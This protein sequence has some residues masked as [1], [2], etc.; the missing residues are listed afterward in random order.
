MRTT[1]DADIRLECLE[2]E[3][4]CAGGSGWRAK[5]L[6]ALLKTDR[7]NPSAK[8]TH[9]GAVQG[10]EIN[11]QPGKS[12]LRMMVRRKTAGH[13]WSLFVG[14]TPEWGKAAYRARQAPTTTRSQISVIDS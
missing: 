3:A 14:A 8:S 2:L 9:P 12:D 1:T 4:T 5:F 7:T 11:K 13:R 6:D 10:D